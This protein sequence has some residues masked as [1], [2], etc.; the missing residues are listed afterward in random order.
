MLEKIYPR[1]LKKM[2][3]YLL[4]HYPVV[5]K[6]RIHIFGF[7]SLI[8]G[9]LLALAAGY[10]Y[11]I[12]KTNVLTISSYSSIQLILVVLLAF[13]V[14]GYIL[15]QRRFPLEQT[16]VWRRVLIIPLYVFCFTSV[17]MNVSV[18][19]HTLVARTANVV[20]NIEFHEHSMLGLQIL[21]YMEDV[22]NFSQN[23]LN[24]EKL[25]A[26]GIEYGV[27]NVELDLEENY[28]NF[29]QAM[30]LE[31][32]L[33]SVAS[34]KYYRD[35]YDLEGFLNTSEYEYGKQEYNSPLSTYA[36]M[37]GNF[38]NAMIFLIGLFSLLTFLITY[39]E[40]KGM[41]GL[42][43]GLFVTWF[44]SIFVFSSLGFISLIGTVGTIII[45]I[46]LLGAV[47]IL[48]RNKTKVRSWVSGFIMVLLFFLGYFL[49]TNGLRAGYYHH[50]IVQ[51]IVMESLFAVL[52]GYIALVLKKEQ[53]PGR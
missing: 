16:S 33:S 51:V 47:P 41:L 29:G 13:I 38:W 34:A 4:T 18:F 5:W 23:N 9:N 28:T 36:S 31:R 39:F 53:Q 3:H 7:F 14:L 17:V 25:K 26:L 45:A 8:M 22:D 46:F 30:Q 44:F 15:V 19:Q 6:S 49:Y 40:A 21:G 43:F 24:V 2:D 10:L 1:F 42:F 11:P 48:W 12:S 27:P 52:L 37:R 32:I 35:H 50:S 20:P